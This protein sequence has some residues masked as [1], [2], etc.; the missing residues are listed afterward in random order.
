M[1]LYSLHFLLLHLPL[2]VL[3]LDASLLPKN[4]GLAKLTQLMPPASCQEE[5]SAKRRHNHQRALMHHSMQAR[6]NW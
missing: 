2:L 6:T 3:H 5:L 4:S 1:Y